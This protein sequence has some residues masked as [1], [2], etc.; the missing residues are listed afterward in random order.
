MQIMLR[1]CSSNINF[2]W[3][4]KCTLY[5]LNIAFAIIATKI[6]NCSAILLRIE[7]KKNI[8]LLMHEKLKYFVNARTNNVKTKKLQRAYKFRRTTNVMRHPK[9]WMNNIT[10]WYADIFYADINIQAINA[11]SD[12]VKHWR[13]C[14]I[15]I[16]LYTRGGADGEYSKKGTSPKKPK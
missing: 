5:Y 10:I 9:Q 8:N 15:A 2:L 7:N 3:I 12:N 1:K 16:E 14:L 6:W 13:W 11:D 4:L